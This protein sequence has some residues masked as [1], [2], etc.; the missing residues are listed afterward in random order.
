MSLTQSSALV[1]VILGCGAVAYWK[2]SVT[3][4]DLVSKMDISPVEKSILVHLH[5]QGDDIASNIADSRG[6]HPSSVSRS[7]SNLS[8]RGLLDN[9]GRG[10][11]RL[12]EDGREIARR[13]ADVES[14]SDKAEDDND[15][16]NN[17]KDSSET[18][19]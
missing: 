1:L 10:V 17:D 16:S 6:H 11:Y 4:E 8:D 15:T 2:R 14:I 13:L 7:A 12:T 18:G 5:T 19:S 9:K 3:T